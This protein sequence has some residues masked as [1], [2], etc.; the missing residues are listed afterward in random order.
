VVDMGD[1]AEIADLR[2]V[3]VC[4]VSGPQTLKNRTTSAPGNCAPAAKAGTA[5]AAD[6]ARWAGNFAPGSMGGELE[7]L[8][9]GDSRGAD[10]TGVAP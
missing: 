1:D 6:P 4:Q 8:L 3:D 5:T 10:K 9:P 7:M 2:T